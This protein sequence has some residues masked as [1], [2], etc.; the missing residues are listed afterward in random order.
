MAWSAS[1][2]APPPTRIGS[3]S[4]TSRSSLITSTAAW[5]RADVE[6]ET[7]TARNEGAFAARATLKPKRG[8]FVTAEPR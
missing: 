3:S 7:P 1:R 4:T 6:T 8:V 2:T 5:S